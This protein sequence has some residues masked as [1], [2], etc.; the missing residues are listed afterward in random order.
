MGTAIEVVR[1]NKKNNFGLQVTQKA[2]D[3]AMLGVSLRDQFRNNETRK[4]T[5]VTDITQTTA[6]L[7]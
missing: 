6:E 2:T 1:Q 7:K 4:R 5:R 3:R